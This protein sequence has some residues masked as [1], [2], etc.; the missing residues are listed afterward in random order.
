MIVLTAPGQALK[1]LQWP[2][3]SRLAYSCNQHLG[4]RV[5]LNI[6]H[7]S[8]FPKTAI[9]HV[10]IFPNKTDAPFSERT[11]VTSIRGAKFSTPRITKRN[12]KEHAFNS[13]SR[14]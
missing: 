10:S 8:I 13:D 12:S 11:R 6:L 1:E 3:L 14:T 9:L 5:N 7:V 2:K 4:K